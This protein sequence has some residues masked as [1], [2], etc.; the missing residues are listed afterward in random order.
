MCLNTLSPRLVNRTRWMRRSFSSASRFDQAVG[1]EARSQ[2]RDVAVGDEQ[3]LRDFAER[4]RAVAIERG[5][6]IEARDGAS[7]TAR[8]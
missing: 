3:V 1:G 8:A 4:Q 5:E 7:R 6:E 2:L